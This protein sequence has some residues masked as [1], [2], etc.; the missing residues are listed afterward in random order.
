M[1][2]LKS[3]QYFFLLVIAAA[4]YAG[5]QIIPIEFRAYQFAD[6]VYPAVKFAASSKKTTEKIRLEIM[7]SAKNYDIPIT[8]RDVRITQHGPSFTV[9]IDYKIPVDLRVWK[10]DRK[11][12][13]SAGGVFF[14]SD[15]D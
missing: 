3:R 12:H 14:G 8:T 6:E 4:I 9:E 15:Q 11:F 13:V 1:F 7:Q 10:Y 5:Y 2:G